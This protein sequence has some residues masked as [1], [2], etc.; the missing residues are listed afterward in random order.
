MA[1][2]LEGPIRRYIGLSTDIKP[3][4]GELSP[5]NSTVIAA[6]D[7]PAG[8]SFLESDTGRV[9]R[10]NGAAWL[11]PPVDGSLLEAQGDIVNELMRIRRLL[12]AANELDSDDLID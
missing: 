9:A 7:L 5:D 6:S 10:W 12:E 2:I 3:V 1:V 11:V 8:S 4:V